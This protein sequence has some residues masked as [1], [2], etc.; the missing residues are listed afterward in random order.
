MKKA[1]IFIP[2]LYCI[3]VLQDHLN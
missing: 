1:F 2:E 3:P